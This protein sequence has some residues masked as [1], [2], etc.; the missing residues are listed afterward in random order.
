MPSLHPLLEDPRNVE[1]IRLLQAQPRMAVSE[2]ARRIGMS[3]P[4]V[5]E[6]LA[7]LEE[8]RVIEGFRLDINPAAVG[9]PITL[10]IRVRPFPGKLQKVLELARSL[11]QVTE[12]HRVTG[13]D[14]FI[15]KV[16]L[17]AIE[18]LDQILDRVLLYGETTT[19]VVQSTPVAHRAPPLPL[20]TR[21]S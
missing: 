14:C 11:P 4:A 1:L 12:C 9:L 16:Y 3:A 5:R 10:F 7:R 13:E 8:A 2:L 20:G 19:S 15:M 17:D 18:H 6:R 21:P